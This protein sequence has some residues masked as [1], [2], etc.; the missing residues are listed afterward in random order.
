VVDQAVLPTRVV[1]KPDG[2]GGGLGGVLRVAVSVH[3]AW[4]ESDSGSIPVFPFFV[5]LARNL[6]GQW[7][8]TVCRPDRQLEGKQ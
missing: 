7:L 1:G 8:G 4:R 5:V 6:P 3:G 2:F